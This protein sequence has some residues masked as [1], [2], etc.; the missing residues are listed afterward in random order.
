MIVHV[1]IDTA[2]RLLIRMLECKGIQRLIPN[3]INSL[4]TI[5]MKNYTNN[6]A[7]RL[8]MAAFALLVAFAPLSSFAKENGKDKAEVKAKMELRKEDK[9]GKD[10]NCLRAVG[11]L[12]APGFIKANG[13]TTVA[14]DCD[15]PK[16]IFKKLHRDNG[17]STPTTTPDV[18]APVIS[19]LVSSPRVTSAL[20]EWTT[21][22]KASSKVFYG[23][24]TALDVNSTSTLS[25]SVKGMTK[26][27]E[28]KLA[29]LSA[30]TTYYF[31]VVSKDA[32]GNTAVSS[33]MS[34]TT[35]AQTASVTYPV[36]SNISTA[37]G[38]STIT[39]SWKTNEPSTT[40]V[41]YGTG[42][43]D[44][45]A[46]ST[47]FVS[48]TSLTTDH[49]ITISGLATSTAYNLILESKNSSG[50]R[51]LSNSLSVTTD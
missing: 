27:H 32:A 35:K 12:I 49:S 21:D 28:V 19:S 48:N 16:G 30:S 37:S 5:I 3:F 46:T 18:V 25:A 22:E 11:H 24:S 43:V 50:N 1:R 14:V 8:S 10:K 33:L 42:I 39:A 29:N 34:F 26:D 38:T 31:K 2:P 36:I 44:V 6:K 23:T 47:A 15:L 20:I 51:T 40:K 4:I 9:S 7:V 13:T 45:N 17:T 41:Y